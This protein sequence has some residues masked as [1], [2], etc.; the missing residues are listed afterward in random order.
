MRYLPL[1]DAK[2]NQM[3]DAIGVKSME[4]IYCDVPGEALLGQTIDLPPHQ[5][6]MEVERTISAMAA[7]NLNAADAPSF[8]GGGAYRHHV[9]ASVDAMIQ[10]GEFLT[11]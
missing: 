7:K 4:D 5:G 3:M 8:L 11:A 2:R 9:P 6:E 1:T 10:R